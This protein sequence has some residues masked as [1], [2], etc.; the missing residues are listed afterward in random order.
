LVQL[1]CGRG[2]AGERRGQDEAERNEPQCSHRSSP[3][4]SCLGLRPPKVCP[5]RAVRAGW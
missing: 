4:F 3:V 1:A 5:T 2:R